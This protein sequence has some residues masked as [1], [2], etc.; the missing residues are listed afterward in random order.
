MTFLAIAI[1]GGKEMRRRP[2][3]SLLT[4]LLL[5]CM[6]CLASAATVTLDAVANSGWSQENL[7]NAYLN[8][9]TERGGNVVW[10]LETETLAWKDF[11]AMVA[12]LSDSY[13]GDPQDGIPLGDTY[14]IEA[15]GDA[16]YSP[17]APIYKTVSLAAG[18]YTVSLA[19]D[20]DA[21]NIKG[22]EDDN[23]SSENL[24]NA[25]VQ[26]W[27][28]DGQDRAFGDGSIYYDSA[29]SALDAHEMLSIPLHL[30]GDTDL[31]LFI[32]DLNSLDNVGSVTLTIRPVPVPAA[33]VLLG[34]GLA[35]IV[36]R[37]RYRQK[38][39]R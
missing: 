20:S 6:P 28:S 33:W 23:Y 34:S 24:W 5:S 26:M 37:R 38:R 29:G 13:I 15:G 16:F 10:S 1:Q 21:Y 9:L 35:A 32:N 12:D 8:I 22:Y 17:E 19:Q 11:G 3:R 30:T 31:N 4:I 25:Y 7:D 2:F 36:G 39:A 14:F 27:T 18:T